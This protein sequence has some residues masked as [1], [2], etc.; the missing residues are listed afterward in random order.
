M[1]GTSKCIDEP[2]CVFISRGKTSKQYYIDGKYYSSSTRKRHTISLYDVLGVTPKA[3]QTQIKSAYYKLSKI[4]HPDTK[5]DGVEHKMFLDIN[6]A[7]EV[8]GN[9]RKRRLY[10]RGVFNPQQH[11]DD[12]D[13]DDS[14]FTET[15]PFTQRE[16][17]KMRRKPPTGRSNVYNFD[18]FYRQHY[19]E[20]MQRKK[21]DIQHDIKQREEEK[22]RI[23]EEKIGSTTCL[24]LVLFT[25][26]VFILR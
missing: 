12:D 9:I 17:F 18:E 3:T 2:G 1:T 6:E 15:R 13:K 24:L 20:L 10:D 21:K 7:Y 4:H 11:D 5:M 23:R 14:H 26:V 8:L 16:G 22:L 19:P 25:F